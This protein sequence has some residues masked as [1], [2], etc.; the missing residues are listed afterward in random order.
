MKVEKDELLID[1]GKSA[2]MTSRWPL[3][4]CSNLPDLS[5]SNWEVVGKVGIVQTTHGKE[6]YCPILGNCDWKL[7]VNWLYVS[8][9]NNR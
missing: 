2:V 8:C 6:C 1:G 7:E 9:K 4:D 5:C 3:T